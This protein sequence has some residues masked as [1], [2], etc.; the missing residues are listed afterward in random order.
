MAKKCLAM[1]LCIAMV[2]SLVTLPTA[3]AEEGDLFSD[4]FESWGEVGTT[5][6]S[7]GG[8]EWDANYGPVVVGTDPLNPDNKVAEYVAS[9]GQQYP[10]LHKKVAMAVGTT[11]L[12][13]G[14]VMLHPTA[15]SVPNYYLQFRNSVD[16]SAGHWQII[17]G[18]NTDRITLM[19]GS[20]S[21]GSAVA[22]K[23][24]SYAAYITPGL[25][26]QVT[27]ILI[28]L[29]S[30]DG[31]LDASGEPTNT[32][33]MEGEGV[34]DNIAVFDN[35]AGNMVHN[36]NVPYYAEDN[37]ARIYLDDVRIYNTA[38]LSTDATLSSLSYNGTPI[39]EFDPSKTTYNI[40]VEDDVDSVK[41]TAQATDTNAQIESISPETLTQFPGSV[42]VTVKSEAGTT[43]VY[44]IY[45]SKKLSGDA[46]VASIMSTKGNAGAIATIISDDGVITSGRIL[47][48]LTQK[49]EIPV[50]CAGIV[51][52]SFNGSSLAEWQEIESHGWI[53]VFN[54]SWTHPNRMSDDAQYK[55][56]YC[57]TE[58]GLK[59]ELVDSKEWFEQNFE[60]DAI[61]FAAPNNSMSTRGWEIMKEQGYYS[62]R[63]GSR[64]F[65]NIPPEDGTKAGQ[66][67]NLHMQGIGDGA[68]N[69]AMRNGWVD[70]AIKNGQWLVE[71]WHNVS[72]N[73]TGGYQPISR[74]AA[75][76]HIAYMVEKRDA[77]ELWIAGIVEATK[78][79]REYQVS[80][81]SAAK[82]ADGKVQAEV[83]YPSDALP[84]EIFDYPLTVKVEVPEEWGA[85]LIT[86]N[87]SAS[88]ATTFVEGNVN[89]VY[90]DIVPNQGVAVLEDAGASNLLS[91][92]KLNG[93]SL[94]GFNPA[95][96]TYEI[97]KQSSE[98]PV[99][100]TAVPLNSKVDVQI[101][102]AT[103]SEVPATVTIT[104]SGADIDTNVY[105]LNFIHAKSTNNLL[106]GITVNGVSIGNFTADGTSYSVTTE[107]ADTEATI[108]ATAQDTKATVSYDP[109]ATITLPGT[110]TITVTAENGS[111]KKYTVAVRSRADDT[112][113]LFDSYDSYTENEQITIGKWT[114]FNFGSDTTTYG[115]LAVKDPTDESN[116]VG[117]IFNTGAS[118]QNQQMNKQL[119]ATTTEPVI[120]SGRFMVPE[121]TTESGFDVL[122]RGEGTNLTTVAN[123]KDGD[124]MVGNS[125]VADAK[126]APDKWISY[127]LVV[128]PASGKY[129]VTGYFFGDGVMDASGVPVEDGYLVLTRDSAS[130]S[131]T[132]MSKLDCRILV[133]GNV[134]SSDTNV[135]YVDDIR[136]YSPGVFKL[137][138]DNT[139]GVDTTDGIEVTANHDIAVDTITPEN[140]IVKA[141]NNDTVAVSDVEITGPKSFRV[142]FDTLPANGSYTLSL[143]DAATDA[144]GQKLSAP[145]TFTVQNADYDEITALSIDTP[146]NLSQTYD[147]MQAVTFTV[148]TTPAENVYTRGIEWY[149]NDEKQETTG[150]TFTYTPADDG[151]SYNVYAKVA[152]TE[153]KT[154]TRTIT[155]TQHPIVPI[156]A[157]ALD[158]PANISQT[159]GNVTPVTFTALTTPDDNVDVSTI[160]WYL[161]GEKQSTTGATFTFTPADEVGSYTV[162][163]KVADSD[164]ISDT[165][166]VSVTLRIPQD[167]VL[168]LDEWV[169]PGPV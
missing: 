130:N 156:T 41:V 104:L 52:S 19:G 146:D 110:V 22:D 90:A 135:V 28:V 111:E 108:V 144:A 26:G 89:Y 56:L 91:D 80:S 150:L 9:E 73:G 82:T 159:V 114:G 44:T 81:V 127:V 107:G 34:F 151:M 87:G 122:V 62:A 35:N 70:T 8:T 50:S 163:A 53:E 153:I 98:L 60:T 24:I 168:Y 99:E 32:I 147:N 118:G 143:A 102:Q 20:D 27:K 21:Y 25:E 15:N 4:N 84:S 18:I 161:N 85:V 140:V 38:S 165:K 76:E 29:T 132:D 93:V 109:G 63:L 100:I 95:Q 126:Y 101:S 105:T 2:L 88:T 72:E 40:R 152:G 71:M 86:Q 11:T 142:M 3:F 121:G 113:Y 138:M 117:R 16:G 61:S 115:V 14:R 69:T 65:N 75:E 155:V 136:I 169:R 120:V 103:V 7:G 124:I 167:D 131:L 128:K 39:G 58:E 51:S 134:A 47:D 112:E 106:S 46:M 125:R 148:T 123:F 6:P 10:P 64:G 154:E 160:E 55:D 68:N 59:Q 164:V 145:L 137:S 79:L 97:E 78:Y 36:S 83:T 33:T 94:S 166:T 48:E 92:I 96:N 162:Y 5:I 139:E 57:N 43:K 37:S 129:T 67:M 54:H 13:S 158:T 141:A 30:E 23:W 77:G 66:W 119:G 31:L 12:F 149:V 116:M 74:A 133:R 45:F 157:L 49:Y 1:L 42:S 17:F